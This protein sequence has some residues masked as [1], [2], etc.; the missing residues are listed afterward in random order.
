MANLAVLIS[1]GILALASLFGVSM[2]SFVHQQTADLIKDNERQA[3]LRQLY[4]L[5]PAERFDND[6]VH[7]RIRIDAATLLGADRI[8]VYRAR[9]QQQDVA[10]VLAPV[11]PDGYSGAIRLLVA[12]NRDGSLAGV[13]VV[14]HRETPGLGDGIETRKSD[15]ILAFT[16]K[17][18]GKPPLERWKVKKDGGNFDQFSGATITPRAIVKAVKNSLLFVAEHAEELYQRPAETDTP[19]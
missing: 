6:L 18:L 17:M 4:A 14:S 13:R 10:L 5:V 9:K 15:W 11:A 2:V 7:D 12:V 8:A 19:P 16:G 3:L 1:A